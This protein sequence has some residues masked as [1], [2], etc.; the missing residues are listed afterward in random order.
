MSNM[1]SLYLLGA[2]LSMRSLNAQAASQPL[3]EYSNGALE[4]TVEHARPER[5]LTR[6][7]QDL[8]GILTMRL[9]NISGETLTVV[10]G[11]PN[12]DFVID[13]RDSSGN[14]PK[15]TP[16]GEHLPKSEAERA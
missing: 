2:I 14:P 4:L 12:C 10:S 8:Y 1:L 5:G 3:P 7:G 15:L 9:K 11:S 6:E 16:L 13:I